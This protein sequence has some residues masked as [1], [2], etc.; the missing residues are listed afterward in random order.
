MI[1]DVY[2]RRIVHAERVEIL[3]AQAEESRSARSSGS[4]RIVTE[5]SSALGHSSRGRSR[6]NSTPFPSR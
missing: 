6:I 1:F 5:P 3:R 4:V 2:A